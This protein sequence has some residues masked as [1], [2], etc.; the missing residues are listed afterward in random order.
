MLELKIDADGVLDCPVC[1]GNYLHQ[2]KTEIFERS[3]D[4][5]AGLHLTVDSSGYSE[6]RN[7]DGNPSSRRHG[8]VIQFNCEFC[9]ARPELGIYQHKGQTFVKWLP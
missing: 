9:S 2:Y 5:D 1:G 8:L 4:A 7:L 3:E 6:S